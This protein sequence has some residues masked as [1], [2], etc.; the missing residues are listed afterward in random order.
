MAHPNRQRET[1]HG[2]IAMKAIYC[3]MP[4]KSRVAARTESSGIQNGGT[5]AAG[6]LTYLTTYNNGAGRDASRTAPRRSKEDEDEEARQAFRAARIRGACC[7]RHSG[8][9]L[10]CQRGGKD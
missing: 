7:G 1:L 4:R 10:H 5:S 8:T 9:A 3:R 6:N 2:C